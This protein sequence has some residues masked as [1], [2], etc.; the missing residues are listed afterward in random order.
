M[1]VT[2]YATHIFSVSGKWA[3]FRQASMRRSFGSVN[4]QAVAKSV[5]ILEI[6]H[7]PKKKHRS[8]ARLLSF[9]CKLKAN[10]N[11]CRSISKYVRSAHVQLQRITWLFVINMWNQTQT[12]INSSC[13]RKNQMN[14]TTENMSPRCHTLCTYIDIEIISYWKLNKTQQ[15]CR[16]IVQRCGH[17]LFLEHQ[18]SFR[19]QQKGNSQRFLWLR[20]MMSWMCIFFVY[21][22]YWLPTNKCRNY[23]TLNKG[24]A[25][26]RGKGD[27]E[28]MSQCTNTDALS[29]NDSAIILYIIRKINIVANGSNTLTIQHIQVGLAFVY[30]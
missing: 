24:K 1:V 12:S 29:E 9:N 27:K 6:W 22:K 21:F 30:K 3:S 15:N 10:E 13:N 14:C 20:S 16:Q 7:R 18:W 17:E 19:L 5:L 23:D 28:K 8:S 26:R 2:F 25:D 4:L 11:Y